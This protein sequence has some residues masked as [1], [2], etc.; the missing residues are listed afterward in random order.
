HVAAVLGM[1]GPL[2]RPAVGASRIA[3][4]DEAV[5]PSAGDEAL[6]EALQLFA[7]A[8]FVRQ[9]HVFEVD[10]LGIHRGELIEPR[11]VEFRHPVL[12]PG[13]IHKAPPLP[14]RY[15]PR[16]PGA[17]SRRNQGGKSFVASATPD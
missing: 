16:T 1:P 3:F 15:P 14:L 17:R 6:E 7:G 8:R 5:L 10:A 2:Y 4:H 13:D 9:R 12:C 11:G